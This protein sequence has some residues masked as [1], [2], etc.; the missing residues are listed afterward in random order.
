M[1]WDYDYRVP[2][3]H[4]LPHHPAGRSRFGGGGMGRRR[5]WQTS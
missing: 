4:P 5:W 1:V 2:Q 3:R